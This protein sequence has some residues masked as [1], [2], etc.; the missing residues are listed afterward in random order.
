NLTTLNGA[1]VGSYG[2][3]SLGTDGSYTYTLN[4]ANPLVQQ[5]APTDTLT[6]TYSYTLTDK[7]G[8]T[9]TENLTITI[10]GTND[11]PVAVADTNTTAENVTLTVAAASGVL[12]NDTDPDSSDTHTVSAVNGVPANVASNVTGSNGGTFAIA[13]NGGYSFNPGAAFDDLAVG[14]TRTTSVDYTNTDNNGLS[15]STTLTITVTG[16]NDAPVANPVSATGTED[17]ATPIAVTLTGTDVD[18]TVSTFTISTLPPTGRLYYD[19]A[20][21]LMVGLGDIVTATGNAL[22]LYYQPFAGW[23]G[24]VNFNYTATDNNGAVSPAAV[25]TVTV[26]DVNDGLPAAANDS[27]LTV[28]SGTLIISKADLLGNDTLPDHAAFYSFT[29]PTGGSLVDNG[30]GTLTYTAP[31]TI[32]SNTF[33]Y[34]VRDDQGE[35]ST[36]TVT[37]GVSNA[38]DDLVTVH[39][40]ALPDGNGGGVSVVTGNL[41]TNDGGLNT[42]ISQVNFNG[43]TWITDGSGSDTDARAGYIGVDTAR[44]HMVVDITGPGAGGY[45]YT[46][47]APADN[48]APAN[49]NS[50]VE[51][52]NYDA[53]NADAALRV[54]IKDDAPTAVNQNVGVPEGV[55]PKYSLVLTVDISGSMSDEERSVASDGTVTLTNRMAMAK[56]ALKELVDEYFTQSPDVQVKIVTFNASSTIL[57]GNNWY[58]TKETAFTAIDALTAS[59]GTNYEAGLGNTMTAMG[60]SGTLDATRDYKVYFVSDGNPTAGDTTNPAVSTGYVTYINTNTVKSFGVGIGTG[61]TNTF[62]LDGIHNVDSDGDGVENSAILVPDLNKLDEELLATVPSAYGGNVVSANGTQGVTFGAD[63]G[64]IQS[65]ALL[66]DSDA[67]GVADRLVTFTYNRGT[68]QITHDGGA[69]AGSSPIA[70][71]NLALNSGRGFVKGTLVFNFGTGDYTYFTSGVA[72]EGDSF[73]LAFVARDMDGD[74][75]SAVQT[76]T[77]IDGKPVA[78]SDSDTLL[79]PDTYL[80][81][82]VITGVGT[83]GGV[84]LGAQLTDFT[85]QGSGVDKIVDGAQVSS[86]VFKTATF[87][88]TTASSGSASGGT[89]TVSGGRLTW[90]HASDGSQL[91]FER[92]GYYKYTP[93]TAEV[94]NPPAGAVPV[95][96]VL[97][98]SNVVV[99]ENGGYA[100]FTIS[101]SAASG[102]D[103]T[104]NLATATGGSTGTGTATSG[105]DYN[106]TVQVWNGSAWMA[107][108]SATIAAGQ[109][110]V[111][112]RVAILDNDGSTENWDENFRLSATVTSGQTTNT[113]ATGYGVIAEDDHWNTTNPAVASINDVVVSEAAGTATFTVSLDH[114]PSN[115][116]NISWQTSNGSATA[117]SDYTTNSGTVSFT[118]TGPLTQ[119]VTV[120]IANDGTF[121]GAET[122]FVNLTSTSDAARAIL[123]DSRG[124]AT[125]TNNDAAAPVTVAFTADPISSGITLQG[126]SRTSGVPGSAA[127]NYT[128]D[129]VGVTGSSYA[130]M[131]DLETVMIDFNRASYPQGVETL[132]FRIYG[133]NSEGGTSSVTFTFYDIHGNELGQNAVSAADGTAWYTMPSKYSNVGR[134][135]ALVGDDNYYT[136]PAVRIR[137]MSFEI[138]GVDTT[139]SAIPPEEI[140][141]TLT[142]TDGDSSTATLT[143]NI[144]TNHQA[145]TDGANDTLTGTNANDMISGL[146]G[147]DT[148]SGGIGADVLLGGTGTD[149]L[150]GD[151]GNDTLDGGAGND[152][153]YGDAGNDIVRGGDGDDTLYGGDGDDRLE[154]GA[155]NDILSGGAGADTLLGGAGN[156]TLSGGLGDFTTDVFRWE[157]ADRGSKGSPATDT[158]TDFDVAPTGSGGDVL[159]LRDLLT[160]ESHPSGTGNLA[161][162][163]HFEKVGGDTKVHISSTG[164]FGGGF[165]ASI[166]DQVIVLQNTD[167][168]GGFTTDQQ[169]ILDLLNKGKLQTD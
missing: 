18:G 45:T 90:A 71:G 141:Y 143:L 99:A 44:G 12:S 11:A 157:L 118:A 8:D 86:I 34:T 80:E 156:D 20:M 46:L 48:S 57:N 33:T 123:G 166:E 128:T 164:G 114:A 150:H 73:D 50:I 6:E 82:N 110:S 30:N 7:D 145:G 22:T 115:N 85:P 124:I 52:F 78:G 28:T 138:C 112:A 153:L 72:Q 103:T 97:S 131:D 77:V 56:T 59:G 162:F 29:A 74:T 121:E 140:R 107:A 42:S 116:V 146:G 117:G 87:D 62:H 142:D 126:M 91:I 148:I 101:L 130:L 160:G 154:G 2:T 15:A 37:I 168:V 96:P 127:L 125:I 106:A 35:T 24:V 27:Y 76:I 135:T 119:T 36:G 58:V 69:Y 14:E 161:N 155:G 65:I 152:T 5:L 104:F 159:D 64:Y 31:A 113:T 25:A 55:V 63:G 151:A 100:Q 169:V 61:I 84:A 132:R 134:V 98:V 111:Q 108:T 17:P 10:T 16:T 75:A 67:N 23:N 38:R 147:N 88:L 109:T 47:N 79:A 70:G 43:G 3:I 94:P 49:N 32:G 163:L 102:T 144:V 129:G 122:F 51:A 83:D 19:A 92:D 53:N 89:Y 68:D 158:V 60:A 9:S 4:N 21:T 120:N 81:G 149:T 1:A 95:L 40:S 13:A 165:S 93:P 66:L 137:E 136:D 26:T 133:N 54:T 139:T 39:E 105:S 167:L 41:F